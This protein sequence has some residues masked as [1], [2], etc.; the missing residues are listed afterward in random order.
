M[1]GKLQVALDLLELTK[2]VEISTR[3]VSAVT[4]ENLWIEVGT[5]LLKSWGKIAVKAL[6]N[7]TDCF[8]VADT[9]TMDVPEVEGTAVF[10]AGADAYTILAVADDEVVKEGVRFAHEKGKI[11]IADLINHPNP[12]KR[13]VELANYGVDVLLFHIGISVQ[14]ARGVSGKDLI[15]EVRELRRLVSSKI[16]VAGGLKPGDIKP[17][18]DSGVDIVIVGGAITKS[19]EPEN[20]VKQ[21]LE[22]MGYG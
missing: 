19:P 13:G 10:S 22:E 21:I 14:K 11:V 16:S 17:L 20:V 12:L 4:C 6:K 5:P 3:I 7:I 15:N 2:A 8:I 1:P 9:K 18:I